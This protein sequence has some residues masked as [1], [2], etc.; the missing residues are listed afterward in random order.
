MKNGYWVRY[1]N[2]KELILAVSGDEESLKEITEL[3]D[4]EI[5]GKYLFGKTETVNVVV[6]A[7]VDGEVKRLEVICENRKVA[8]EV[9]SD[10]RTD[11][12]STEILWVNYFNL[13]IYLKLIIQT[14]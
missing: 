2:K 4:M 11:V 12:K 7:I 9:I 5:E 13:N 1:L 14:F 8:S 6:E 10:I 3:S